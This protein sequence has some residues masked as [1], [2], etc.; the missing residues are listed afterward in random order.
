MT[1]NVGANLLNKEAQLG[2]K[3]TR[4]D[5]DAAKELERSHSEMM[6]KVLGRAEDDLQAEFLNRIDATIVFRSLTDRCMRSQTS[7]WLASRTSW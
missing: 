4:P 7:F 1:S 5:D 6:K 3:V 2:F